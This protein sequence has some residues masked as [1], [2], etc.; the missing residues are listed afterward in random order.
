MQGGAY[1]AVTPPIIIYTA[2]QPW[3]KD[4]IKATMIGF[5][6]ATTIL[7]AAMHLAM[8]MITPAVLAGYGAAF[9]GLALG[10]WAGMRCYGHVGD[11]L[12]RRIIALLLLFLGLALLAKGVGWLR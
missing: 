9:P 10:L 11:A 1:C 2:L 12:Y 7:V 3:T 5:F 6:L 4:R 8:G